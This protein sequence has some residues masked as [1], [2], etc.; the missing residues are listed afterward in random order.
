MNPAERSVLVVDDHEGMARSLEMI[1]RRELALRVRCVSG[2]QEAL[3]AAREEIP[4]VVIT[5]MRRPEGE[6]AGHDLLLWLRRDPRTSRVPV[7]AMSTGAALG[8]A[9]CDFDAVLE[10]PFSAHTLVEHVRRLLAGPADRPTA[11]D[12]GEPTEPTEP[13]AAGQPARAAE[14]AARVD[15]HAPLESADAADPTAPGTSA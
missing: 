2:T 15:R 9:R 8:P 4:A 14:P 11:G 7:I 3:R 12:P 1:L 13:A 5:D 10:K 6:T